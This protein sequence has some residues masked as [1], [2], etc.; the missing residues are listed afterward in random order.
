MRAI[1]SAGGSGNQRDGV[2]V[3]RVPLYP[4]HS[5]SGLRRIVNYLSFALSASTIGT[6]LCGSADMMWV[7]HPPLTVGIPAWWIGSLRRIPFVYE[8]QDMWPETLAATGML[9][10]GR[11]GQ[12]S[13]SAG[14]FH[15]CAGSGHH[16]HLA[17]FQAQSYRERRARRKDSRHP[18]LGR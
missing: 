6:A 15:L 17:R 4:N 7:Y 14:P 18:Q 1:I 9:P 10:S 8:M 16:R 12:D 5:R 11:V 13:G 3:L 2:R